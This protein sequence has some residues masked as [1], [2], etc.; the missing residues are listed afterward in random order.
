MISQLTRA[1]KAA[2]IC[3]AGLAMLSSFA[4]K[5]ETRKECEARLHPQTAIVIGGGL[6]GIGGK[7]ASTVVCY[8][9]LASAPVDFGASTAVCVLL[10][11]L[12]GTAVG[13]AAAEVANNEQSKQ[14]AELA[15]E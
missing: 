6:G 9:L 13:T 14:C 1:T 11:T 12:F 8:P 10:V 7:V 2:K 3:F 4:A 15:G 5:A